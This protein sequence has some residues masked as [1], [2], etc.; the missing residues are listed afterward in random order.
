[1]ETVTLTADAVRT[2]RTR[3]YHEGYLAGYDM[4]HLERESECPYEEGTPE[5]D[6]WHGGCDDA[7]GDHSA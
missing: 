2:M 4:V 7:I 3:E 6:N 1:M 5:W